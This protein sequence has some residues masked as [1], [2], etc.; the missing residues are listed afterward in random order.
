MKNIP[1][2][3]HCIP[4]PDAWWCCDCKAHTGFDMVRQ[5]DGKAARKCKL[6]ERGMFKIGDFQWP[7]AMALW[8]A[9]LLVVVGLLTIWNGWELLVAFWGSAAVFGLVGWGFHY[10]TKKWFTWCKSQERKTERQLEQEALDHPFQP[11]YESSP[12]F[13]EWAGQF[14]DSVS[15]WKKFRRKYEQDGK[16]AGENEETDDLTEGVPPSPPSV[17][18]LDG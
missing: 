5:A 16:P 7:K 3:N 2:I 8:F 15:R 9:K 18:L 13:H 12:D 11:E 4:S 14:F 1:E 17:D 10:F 6:C